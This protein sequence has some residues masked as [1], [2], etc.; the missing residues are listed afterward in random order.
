[1]TKYLLAV[2]CI[3]TLTQLHAQKSINGRIVDTSTNNNIPFATISYNNKSGVISNNAG[4]F[5]LYINEAIKASD[6]LFFSCLGYENKSIAALQYTDS[7][8]YLNPKSIELSEVLVSNKSYTAEEIIKKAYNNLKQNYHPNFKK[9][10]LFLR[11]S[12]YTNYLKNEAKL[13]TSTIP[14]INQELIDSVLTALPKQTDIHIETLAQLYTQNKAELATKLNIKKAAHLYDKNNELSIE[15][16]ENRFNSILKK[17]IKRNSYFK[18][19]SGIFGVKQEIDSSLF[20]DNT[21]AQKETENFLEEQQKKEDANKQHF[22]NYRKGIIS[23]IENKSLNFSYPFLEFLKKSGKY[24]FELSDYQFI[25]NDFAYKILFS[26]KRGADY[27]GTVYINT[28]DFAVVRIDY[29]NVKHLRNFKLFGVSY[30]KTVHKGIIMYSKN[31][32]TNTYNLKY[33]ES[34]TFSDFSIKRPLK[35]IEKNKHTKGRRK[36]N[37]L[38]TDIHF[39]ISNK[40]KSE[41]VVFENST[42]TETDFNNFTEQPKVKPTYLPNYDPEFWNGYNVIEPNQAIRNFKS[43]K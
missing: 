3:I 34:E 2:Y 21:N 35:I 29:E 26:P 22:L 28:S 23:N 32:T 41:L 6:S 16:L 20:D 15:G 30:N 27:K 4:H 9:S 43:L 42:I 38:E 40:A 10:T 37:E 14:E 1:M 33:A 13:T 31:N 7:I 19:K 12:F 25:D 36:Q 17:R 5:Q 24:N 8:V 39:I 18:I 11:E